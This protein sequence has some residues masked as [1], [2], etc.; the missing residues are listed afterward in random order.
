M[1][2]HL[3]SVKDN[4]ALAHWE[5]GWGGSGLCLEESHLAHPAPIPA[6][7]GAAGRKSL[8]ILEVSV[9]SLEAFV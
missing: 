7:F 6:R 3:V 8:R 5:S 2:S 9:I 1:A 4:N